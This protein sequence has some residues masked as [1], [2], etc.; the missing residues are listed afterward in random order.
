[1]GIGVLARPKKAASGPKKEADRLAIVVTLK[2]ST[3]WKAWVDDLAGHCRTDVSK[4]IDSALVEYARMR[5][6][7]REAPRR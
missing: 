1:M 7:S 4:L 3:E 2:G 5:G 6:F